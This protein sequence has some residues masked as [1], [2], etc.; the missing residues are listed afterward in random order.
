MDD[1]VEKFYNYLLKTSTGQLFKNTNMI[2]QHGVFN[3]SM[4]IVIS[5]IGDP[6]SLQEQLDKLI[7]NHSHY[8]ITVTNLNDFGESFRKCLKDVFTG[9][10]ERFIEVW[11]KIMISITNYFEIKLT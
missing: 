7:S 2:N 3:S 4:G 11:D 6:E 9:P 8:G 5:H 10:S 1:L